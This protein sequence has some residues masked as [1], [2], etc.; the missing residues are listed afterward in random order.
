LQ[1]IVAIY[2]NSVSVIQRSAGK[3][4]V[5]AAAYRSGEKLKD[6]RT[7]LT[8][9]YTRKSGVDYSV[10]LTP[11]A[12]DWI[13]DRQQLW[14]K[15]EATERRG[16]AQLAREITVAIPNELNRENK[17]KLVLEYVQKN[18]VELGMIADVNFHHLDSDNPHA[19]IMVT[20]RDLTIDERGDVSFGNKNRGWNHKTLLIKN[21]EDWAKIANQYLIDAGYPDSQIDHRSNADRGI[22]TIPQI[23][24][25]AKATAMRKKGTAS[26]RS[27]EY[28]RIENANDNIRQKLEQIFQSESATRDLEQQLVEFDRQVSKRERFYEKIE[29]PREVAK[30]PKPPKLAYEKWSLKREI[31]PQLVSAIVEIG[32]RLGTNYEAGNYQIQ[33]HIPQREI[34]VRYMN[35]LAMIVDISTCEALVT[36]RTFNLQQYELGLKKSLDVLV[37]EEQ[38]R[39]Q[40]QAKEWERAEL[41]RQLEQQSQPELELSPEIIDDSQLI[42]DDV[43]IIDDPKIDFTKPLANKNLSRGS[44]SA[45]IGN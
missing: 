33:I 17:I 3:S 32:A 26:K 25:G 28:D 23:H 43:E 6:E 14:N 10:I 36:D 15:V 38:Q 34:E 16:D 39:E 9:D 40:S 4:S 18:Y 35:N 22:E 44:R 8:H 20:M 13:A 12:A 19:H 2:H 1:T 31:D 7:G 29:K 27:N 24:L 5:A 11:V 42:I 37:T 45:G 21:R 30:P 41:E